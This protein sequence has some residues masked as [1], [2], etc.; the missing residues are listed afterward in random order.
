M[1]KNH[2]QEKKTEKFPAFWWM[3][4][5]DKTG[6][7]S[8]FFKKIVIPQEIR[9]LGLIQDA[10]QGDFW[11]SV[12]LQCIYYSF[13]FTEQEED[14]KQSISVSTKSIVEKGKKSK[15]KYFSR[16]CEE[17]ETRFGK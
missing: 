4:F 10:K 15:T 3:A 16:I 7:T 13:D 14:L 12:I 9:T 8:D 5:Q 6:I 1:K 17:M 11:T 2:F